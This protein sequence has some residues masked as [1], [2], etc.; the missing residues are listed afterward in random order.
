[1]TAAETW[2]PVAVAGA[3]ELVPLLA[4]ELRAGGEAAAVHERA[5]AEG[6]AVLV[7]LGKPDADALRAASL[8][9]VPIVGV[10]D[11]ASLPYVLDTDL[12]VVGPGEGLPVDRIGRAIA[13]CVDDGWPGLAARL[14]VLRDALVEAAI[15]R[16]ALLNAAVAARSDAAALPALAVTCLQLWSAIARAFGSPERFV[17]ALAAGAG[18]GALSRALEARA[19][20]APW[21]L[22]AAVAYAATR[23]VGE[24]AR[25]YYGSVRRRS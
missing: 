9:R 16:Q 24:A 3:R 12:V 11:G 6:A 2:K 4:R 1:V 23:A 10:T 17:P 19:R 5:R 18:A 25:R 14:P 22:R 21:A 7:W 8:A 15:R 13:A 20:R